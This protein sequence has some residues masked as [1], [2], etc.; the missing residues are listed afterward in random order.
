LDIDEWEFDEH[1][2]KRAMQRGITGELVDIVFRSGRD[3]GPGSA[4][5]TT[6]RI[7][8][9]NGDSVAVVYWPNDPPDDPIVVH[10][11]YWV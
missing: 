6:L 5:G 9:V 7:G 11:V 1:G 10:T 4:P 3:V 8:R 2:E